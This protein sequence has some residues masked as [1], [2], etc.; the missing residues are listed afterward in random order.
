[1]GRD[2]WMDGYLGDGWMEIT[3]VS[4]VSAAGCFIEWTYRDV[5]NVPHLGTW[6]AFG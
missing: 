4:R 6:G 1:M 2:G 3:Y 5:L